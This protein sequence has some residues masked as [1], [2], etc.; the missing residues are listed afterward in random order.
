MTEGFNLNKGKNTEDLEKKKVIAYGEVGKKGCPAKGCNSEE[1]N[2][3]GK[4]YNYNRI[5]RCSKC[6]LYFASP[7]TWARCDNE[8]IQRTKAGIIA[9]DLIINDCL[10]CP[11]IKKEGLDIQRIIKEGK[12]CPYFKGKIKMDE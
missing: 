8:F 9:R 12:A 6:K 5:Y 10:I 4:L 7:T 11:I 2:F 1:A 3:T